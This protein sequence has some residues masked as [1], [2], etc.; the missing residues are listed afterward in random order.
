MVFRQVAEWSKSHREQ[1]LTG[2]MQ[3]RRDEILRLMRN[4]WEIMVRDVEQRKTILERF[5]TIL[6]PKL[7]T[8][9]M[10]LM[11]M[12]W[13]IMVGRAKRR[14]ANLEKFEASLSPSYSI[15]R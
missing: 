5:E 12:I 14:K 1:A 6:N 13:E 11:Q 4:I 3:V 10:Q 15:I 2:L 7:C 9:K 8:E